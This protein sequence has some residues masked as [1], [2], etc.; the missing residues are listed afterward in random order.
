ML[1]LGHG[2]LVLGHGRRV[3]AAL[4]SS[5]GVLDMFLANYVI[6]PWVGPFSHMLHTMQYCWLPG[7]SA[8]STWVS[9]L[10][11]SLSSNTPSEGWKLN[12][13]VRGVTPPVASPSTV[14]TQMSV[15]AKARSS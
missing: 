7:E 10:L 14:Q 1:V 8:L 2:V 3:A 5:A 11:A 12:S 6:R 13:A 9:R 15:N 4:L